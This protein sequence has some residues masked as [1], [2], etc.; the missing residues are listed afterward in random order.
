MNSLDRPLDELYLE[1]LYSHIGPPK[2]KNKAKMH[3]SLARQLFTTEFIWFVPNDDNRAED[4]RDLRH[5][6]INEYEIEVIDRDWMNLGCS[7]LEL[8]IGLA[9]RLEFETDGRFRYWFWHLI[10]NLGFGKY[11]DRDWNDDIKKYV[12]QTLDQVIWRTYNRKGYG[13]LFPLRHAVKDQ[14]YEEI[15]YQLSAYLLERGG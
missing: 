8:L 6:F 10:D 1:W 4:G 9:R 13:G 11:N 15:W 7:M 3:W 14:R 2:L 12:G 5:E